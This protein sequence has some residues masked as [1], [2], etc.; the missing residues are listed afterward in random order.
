M[1]EGRRIPCRGMPITMRNDPSLPDT[2]QHLGVYL[3]A[4]RFIHSVEKVGSMIVRIDH[5]I[6]KNRI[7]GFYRWNR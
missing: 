3:G 2:E 6:W 7:A 1:E 5:P 4:G